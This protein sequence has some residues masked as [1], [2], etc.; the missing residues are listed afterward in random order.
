[1]TLTNEEI[2]EEVNKR[3]RSNK[4]DNKEIERLR[5]V[6]LIDE[7]DEEGLPFREGINVALDKALYRVLYGKMWTKDILKVIDE[8]K[9]ELLKYYAEMIK[10]ERD[11]ED[12]TC[13]ELELREAA[14][15]II[16]ASQYYNPD[17]LYR[18]MLFILRALW[19]RGKFNLDRHTHSRYLVSESSMERAM[20]DLENVG[21]SEKIK[22][23]DN[24][25]RGLWVLKGREGD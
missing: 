23:G 8:H 9:V 10:Y 18:T 15:E 22:E 25:F 14:C 2:V 7:T 21:I 3:L 17:E 11:P 19:E 4:F 20:C 1:M 16:N 5:E 13:K 24:N 12:K 6:V